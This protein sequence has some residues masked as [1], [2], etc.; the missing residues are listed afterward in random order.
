[1][2]GPGGFSYIY[3]IYGMYNCLNFVTEPE[4]KPAAVLLRAAEPVEGLALLQHNST[5]K[6][7]S[8]LLKGPGC[9]CRSFGLTTQHSGLDLTKNKL[10][11]EDRG[12]RV[13]SIKR[14]TRV[15]INTG[16]DKK[17]R[18]YDKDS[19]AVSALRTVRA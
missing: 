12:D 11:L 15:G 17:W 6:K 16:T 18:F 10:Y 9:F 1:M 7:V 8:D 13:N 19:P 14:T 3:F 4:N 2:F 5:G